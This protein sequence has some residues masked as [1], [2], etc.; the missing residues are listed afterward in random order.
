MIDAD[1]ENLRRAAIDSRLGRAARLTARVVTAAWSSSSVAR[2]FEAGIGLATLGPVT[3][4]V[5]FVAM[6]LGWAGVAHL[7]MLAVVPPYVAPGLPRFWI[8]FGMAAAIV[9]AVLPD[10]FTRAWPD[11]RARRLVQKREP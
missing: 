7:A 2:W 8:G 3:H 11:S 5:R 6:V 1:F 9:V 4:R 10:A